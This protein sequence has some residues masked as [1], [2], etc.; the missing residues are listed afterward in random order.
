M[1]M[2]RIVSLEWMFAFSAWYAKLED[3]STAMLPG[4]N[5]YAVGELLEV[6]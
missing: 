6:E 2:M 4:Q 1:S 5:N 3:G